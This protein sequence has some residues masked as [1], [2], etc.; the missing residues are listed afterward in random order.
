[1]AV[2]VFPLAVGFFPLAVG[3][4]PL[5]VGCQKS[6]LVLGLFMS[7]G[8]TRIPVGPR[9]Y[10]F[11]FGGTLYFSVVLGRFAVLHSHRGVLDFWTL[12]F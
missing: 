9:C 10:T 6:K 3:F 11:D 2:G 7:V 4:V 1:M 8:P 12:D 5:A